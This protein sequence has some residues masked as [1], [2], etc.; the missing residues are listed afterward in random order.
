M[1]K[2]AKLRGFKWQKK[3][4]LIMN[5][6]QWTNINT[7]DQESVFKTLEFIKSQTHDIKAKM[8]K[9][10]DGSSRNLKKNTGIR[11]NVNVMLHFNCETQIFTNT[12][13]EGTKQFL[14]KK[15]D[16]LDRNNTLEYLLDDKDFET[17]QTE[18]EEEFL[19]ET[20]IESQKREKSKSIKKKSNVAT[21]DDSFNFSESD[22]SSPKKITNIE[23]TFQESVHVT[24]KQQMEENQFKQNDKNVFLDNSESKRRN[25]MDQINKK[26]K[27]KLCKRNIFSNFKPNLKIEYDQWTMNE[28]YIDWMFINQ[29]LKKI[30]ASISPNIYYD[31]TGQPKKRKKI[32]I[33]LPGKKEENMSKIDFVNNFFVK[34]DLDDDSDV[35]F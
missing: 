5:L 4:L 2:S 15:E 14:V 1:V 16:P 25:K 18:D 33:I 27:L 31:I 30:R 29:P 9:K 34:D 17:E 13:D 35:T 11:K 23:K 26:R 6:N 3:D 21:Y 19:K 12:D 24:Q 28:P 10:C 32:K 8:N 7:I 20:G 22:L